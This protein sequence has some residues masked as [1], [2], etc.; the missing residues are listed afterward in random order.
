V[1]WGQY[2]LEDNVKRIDGF[3]EALVLD[4]VRV[5]Q[6]V[7]RLSYKLPN[8]LDSYIQIFEEVDFELYIAAESD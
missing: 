3:D 6:S 4:N 1:I 5:L 2:E 7:N 8:A